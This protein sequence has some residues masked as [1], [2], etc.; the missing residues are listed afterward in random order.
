MTKGNFMQLT[1]DQAEIELAIKN[2]ISSLISI[3]EGASVSVTIA[4]SHIGMGQVAIV[5]I[6]SGETYA[7]SASPTKRSAAVYTAVIPAEV[8]MIAPQTVEDRLTAKFGP[9]LMSAVVV[10]AEVVAPVVTPTPEVT[11]W[12]EPRI[13]VTTLFNKA[14]TP[15][16]PAEVRA[17]MDAQLDY[18]PAETNEKVAE[19]EVEVTPAAVVA[20]NVVN[21]PQSLFKG[22]RKPVNA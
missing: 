18:D 10:P 17:I 13:P 8:P 16:T 12:V 21:K 7:K 19:A 11:P 20:E 1:I 4:E 14:K 9:G 15:Q 22:L 5:D 6:L 2:H 3:R